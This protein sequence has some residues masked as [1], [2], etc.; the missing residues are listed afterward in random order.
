MR[1]WAQC[2]TWYNFNTRCIC[3]G[4]LVWGV[5]ICGA[6]TWECR[7]FTVQVH[8]RA[9]L[10][11]RCLDFFLNHSQ[12]WDKIRAD[13]V[14]GRSCFRLAWWAVS[15]QG[16]LSLSLAVELHKD[17]HNRVRF[18][19]SL[20]ELEIQT[21]EMTMAELMHLPLSTPA[22]L[23]LPIILITVIE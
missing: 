12:S 16:Y 15:T 18:F 11:V 20:W 10:D 5:F 19:F 1:C 13:L 17:K 23:L 2:D 7:E 14:T 9:E 6:C 8:V 3:V 22:S 21:Q 4:C